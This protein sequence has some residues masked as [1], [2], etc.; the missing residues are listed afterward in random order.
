MSVIVGDAPHHGTLAGHHRFSGI[1][2]RLVARIDDWRDRQRRREAYLR[3]DDRLL[4]DIGITRE[5]EL[6][7]GPMTFWNA[8]TP[9]KPND[10]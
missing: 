2:R 8:V 3:L 9:Q 1:V 5:R 10:T 4:A 6:S 7:R